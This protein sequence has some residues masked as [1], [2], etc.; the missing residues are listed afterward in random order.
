MALGPAESVAALSL[1]LH[2]RRIGI[3]AHYTRGRNMLTFDPSYVVAQPEDRPTFTLPQLASSRYFEKPLACSQRLPPVLSNLLPEGAMRSHMAKVL[4]THPDNEFPL[5]AWV[6]QD[7]PG[8]LIATPIKAGEIPGWA[9]AGG[10]PAEPVQIDAKALAQTFSLAGV[11]VKFSSSKKDGRFN[12]GAGDGNGDW[13]VK[14]P[15]TIHTD[16]PANEYSMMELARSMGI[17][18]PET[19]LVPL[20]DLDNLPAI[21]LPKEQW[22]YAIRRF[23]RS[24]GGRIHAEDFAQVFGQYAHDKYSRQSYESVARALG[25]FSRDRLGDAQEMARRL[26]VNTLLG[27]GDAHLKNWSLIYPDQQHPELAPAYDIV[28]TKPYVHED[29]NALNMDKTKVWKHLSMASFERWAKKADIS[30]SAVKPHLKVAMEKARD[31]WPKQIR[32]LPLNERQ[33]SLLREHWGTL[34]PDFRIEVSKPWQTET[35]STSRTAKGRGGDQKDGESVAGGR[36]QPERQDHLFETHDP[37]TNIDDHL[38]EAEEN[39]DSP[40]PSPF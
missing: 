12:I 38:D 9:L 15:S 26:L 18:V 25:M 20:S 30:W 5:F 39:D 4:K 6:G 17:M 40:G 1:S 23:D 32:D 34:S 37:E 19:A 36:C 11:Q 24:P 29:G 22:A 33:K 10:L 3:L 7:L 13:I 27:N 8:A 16:V 35:H 14:T 31:V 28:F 2:G 21:A